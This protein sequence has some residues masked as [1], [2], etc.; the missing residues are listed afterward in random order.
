VSALLKKTLR[1]PGCDRVERPANRFDQRLAAPDLSFT[2]DAL[3]L[4]EDF[5]CGV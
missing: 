2:Q 3:Y 4:A 5:L 1:I